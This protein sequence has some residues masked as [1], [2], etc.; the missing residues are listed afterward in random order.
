MLTGASAAKGSN[1]VLTSIERRLYSP[2]DT[3]LGS[4]GT[5]ETRRD[6]LLSHPDSCPTD[7]VHLR[8]RRAHRNDQWRDRGN[9][10]G[11]SL[12]YKFRQRTSSF[13][14]GPCA[15]AGGCRSGMGG[16]SPPAH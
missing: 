1:D 6:S 8:R 13:R 12:L 3:P 5:L 16:A 4:R 7:G 2:T 10:S 11:R 9:T 14:S 15:A